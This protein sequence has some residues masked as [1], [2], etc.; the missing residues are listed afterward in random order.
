ML[1]DILGW[2]GY[3]VVITHSMKKHEESS[4][5]AKQQVL[6]YQVR[7]TLKNDTEDYLVLES[8]EI[9]QADNKKS[10]FYIFT[11][12]LSHSVVLLIPFTLAVM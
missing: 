5:A 10:Q 6:Q 1:N 9:D 7:E 4:L 8:L 12:V 2:I 11:P 3:C